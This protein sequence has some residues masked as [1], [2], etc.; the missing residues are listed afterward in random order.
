MPKLT[1]HQ[2]DGGNQELQQVFCSLRETLRYQFSEDSYPDDATFFMVMHNGTPAARAAV[3]PNL[4]MPPETALIGFFEAKN[5]PQAVKLLFDVIVEHC[6]TLGKKRVIGPING[7]T[8]QTYRVALPIGEAFFLDVV[9]QPYYQSLFEENGFITLADYFSSK[10]E[11]DANAF[12]KW[13]EHHRIF[14]DQGFSIQTLNPHEAE[15]QLHEIYALSTVGFQNNFLY[16]PI[17]E[18]LFMAKYLPLMMKAD[19]RFIFLLRDSANRLVGYHFAIRNILCQNR[20]ELVQK[21][22]ALSPEFRGRG[23]GGYLME[24]CRRDAWLNGYSVVY[25]ALMHID[26]VSAKFN[27]ERQRAIRRYKLYY[28]DIS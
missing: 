26:N 22:I 18:E 2:F 25:H 27:A 21:T 17:S 1:L 5:E 28:K 10:S 19:P 12:P 3:I 7:S 16:T 13:E 24:N 6:R 15:T 4:L 20:L 23:L 14:T 8:W 9:S 11:L